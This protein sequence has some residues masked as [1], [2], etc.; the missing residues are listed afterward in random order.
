MK[1]RLQVILS[2]AGVASRRKAA[3]IIADGRIS[4]DNV[5]V[6]EKGLQVDPG[7]SKI[8]MD[9]RPLS[10]EEKIFYVLNKPKGVITTASDERG[11]RTVLDFIP[12]KSHRIYPV[13]RLDKDTEG[14]LI[15]TND[16]SAAHRLT[17]PRFGVAKIYA[18]EVKGAIGDGDIKRLEKGVYLDGK[19]T[20]PCVIK[21]V[22]QTPG[23]MTLRIELHEGRKRQ[24]RRMIEKVGGRVTR[25]IRIWYAGI[26]LGSLGRGQYRRLTKKEIRLLKESCMIYDGK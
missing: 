18:V 1:K 2:H 23:R 24:I 17:H 7:Q 10:E 25:L 11:R 8:R 20:Q 9:G 12:L 26:G 19:K 13:G 21:V 6:R 16:G 15:L 22:G 4:V 3:E 5:V 14:A